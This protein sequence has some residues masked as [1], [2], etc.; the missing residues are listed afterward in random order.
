MAA[1][2]NQRC[3][4]C[5]CVLSM[6]EGERQARQVDP[7]VVAESITR[8]GS[9]HRPSLGENPSDENL[10]AQCKSDAMQRQEGSPTSSPERY[11]ERVGHAYPSAAV[12]SSLPRSRQWDPDSS[13]HIPSFMPMAE[14]SPLLTLRFPVADRALNGM[15]NVP[16]SPDAQDTMQFSQRTSSSSERR[17]WPRLPSEPPVSSSEPVETSLRSNSLPPAPVET[18]GGSPHGTGD[19]GPWLMSRKRLPGRTPLRDEQPRPSQTPRALELPADAPER[20]IWHDPHLP[21]LPAAISQER[22]R[23]NTR[24]CLH[25]GAVFQG[26]QRN[27]GNSYS[28]TVEI[29]VRALTHAQLAD[30]RT[31]TWHTRRSAD[32]STSGASRKSG[33][34]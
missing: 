27:G 24:G 5:G 11:A 21:D 20:T 2:Q 13:T 25:P 29:S 30:R 8:L 3:T 23:S 12:T 9:R 16:Q 6:G 10:C 28:V 15:G 1:E 4:S 7:V 34:F 14:T 31:W 32:T 22:I 17:P 19:F 33:R 18:Q 26:T